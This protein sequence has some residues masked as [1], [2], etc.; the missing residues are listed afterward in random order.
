MA[1]TSSNKMSLKKVV[2][3]ATSD[4][5]E[6]IAN[7]VAAEA[8]G[9]GATTFTTD[10]SDVVA[11]G[12]YG[13]FSACRQF[14]VLV[15]PLVKNVRAEIGFSTTQHAVKTK[16]R[17]KKMSLPSASKFRIQTKLL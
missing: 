1:K 17:N 14:V 11:Y 12:S 16:N 15:E 5:H 7:L 10:V 9:L 8:D 4:M 6:A 2:A 13:G 3:D